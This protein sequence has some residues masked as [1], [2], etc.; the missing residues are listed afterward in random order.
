MLG[1]DHIRE[2]R[3]YCWTIGQ[4]PLLVQGAG[5][6]VSLK[7]GRS[8]WIKASGAWLAQA[9][10][11]NIFVELDLD[12]ARH[13]TEEGDEYYG[14]AVRRASDLRPSIETS[15]HVLLPHRIVSH[16]HAVD[17]LAWAVLRDGESSLKPLLE[18]MDWGWI[19]YAKPGRNLTDKVRALSKSGVLPD[20]I[21]LGN[22]GI[23]LGA[24]SFEE[25]L[26]LWSR[27]WKRLSVVPRTTVIEERKVGELLKPWLNANYVLPRDIK[28]YAL[29]LDPILINLCRSSWVLYP[30]H[31]VFLGSECKIYESSEYIDNS[32]STDNS[33]YPVIVVPHVGAVVSRTLTD[34]QSAML[35]CFVE[36]ALRLNDAHSV[37]SLYPLEIASLLNWDAEKYRQRL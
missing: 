36:V 33:Q 27:L 26:E 28:I 4:D 32:T 21:I 8:L 13:L 35:S 31:A 10:E 29:G 6:N 22:H 24:D 9:E 1:G 12:I 20:I 30:D 7:N 23:V 3:Q 5:G 15:L 25:I 11:K 17:V 2:L 16:F 19:E 34:S 18:G 37:R 14:R